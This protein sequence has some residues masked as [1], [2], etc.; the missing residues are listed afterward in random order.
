MIMPFVDNLVTFHYPYLDQIDDIEEL[1]YQKYVQMIKN[2][3]F[4]NYTVVTIKEKE[5]KAL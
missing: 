3:D 1:T 5:L 2:I 4:S